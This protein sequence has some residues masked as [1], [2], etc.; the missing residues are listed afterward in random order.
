MNVKV[1]VMLI[2]LLIVTVIPA[3]YSTAYIM[4]FGNPQILRT[5]VTNSGT[6]IRFS[7]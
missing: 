1:T 3:V 4:M 6:R 5:P 7:G 2:I